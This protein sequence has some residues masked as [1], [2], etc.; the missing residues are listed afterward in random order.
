MFYMIFINMKKIIR[1]TESDLIQIVKRVISEDSLSPKS[2]KLKEIIKKKFNIDLNGK[3][4]QI[5]RSSEIPKIF[6][7]D[8]LRT[9]KDY[10]DEL[11]LKPMYLI[12]FDKDKVMNKQYLYQS[13]GYLMDQDGNFW[14]GT[15]LMK[16]IGLNLIG[17]KIDDLID[18]YYES[19]YDM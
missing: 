11:N 4:K 12:H 19:I 9:P 18:I 3:I 13:G 16:L 17:L 14:T 2:R 10:Q 6:F 5:N 7:H 8:S 15:H 1:L